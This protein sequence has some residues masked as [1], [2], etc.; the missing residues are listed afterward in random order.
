MNVKSRLAIVL[1]TLTFLASIPMATATATAFASP[2]GCNTAVAVGHTSISYYSGN[3]IVSATLDKLVNGYTYAF[4]GSMRVHAQVVIKSGSYSGATLTG[5]ARVGTSSSSGND[6]IYKLGQTSATSPG[7]YNSYG[8][9][10]PGNC[11]MTLANFEYGLPHN[12]TYPSNP[13]SAVCV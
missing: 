3:V 9:W 8:N 13:Y 12:A 5:Y 11:G 6:P 2:S 4:C 1:I 10:E 7:T